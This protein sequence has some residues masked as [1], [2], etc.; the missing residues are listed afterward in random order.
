MAPDAPITM[1]EIDLREALATHILTFFVESRD[2]NGIPVRELIRRAGQPRD[3]VLAELAELVSQGQVALAFGSYSANPH[4]KRLPDLPIDE[5]L[6]RMK[7]ADVDT[8]A[9]AYPTSAVIEQRADLTPYKGQPFTRR[10]AVAD[11]QLTPVFF[12]LEVLEKYFRNPIYHFQ[13][14]DLG[15]NISIADKHY[16]SAEINER[17]KVHIDFGIAYDERRR[18]VVVA[19]L[20]YLADLSPE[21]QRIWDA[22]LAAG[23]CVMNSDYARATINGDFPEH[24][25]AYQAFLVEQVEINK[26]SVLID[27]PPLFRETFEEQK[28]PKEYMPM[29]LPTKKN[30]D[31]FV[32]TLDKMLSENINHD[33]FKGDVPLLDE[34]GR[35]KGTLNLLRDFLDKRYRDGDKN[36]IGVELV[37]PLKEVRDLRRKPAHKLEGDAHDPS[38][39]A[40]QDELL[41]RVIRTLTKLRL[42]LMSHPKAKGQYQPPEWLDGDKIVFY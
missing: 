10:L 17:D 39:P 42:V 21:H 18:R 24:W 38:L 12:D 36:R 31:A 28:R 30:F 16:Q 25:S 35:A 23:P 8:D 13:F 29:L 41:G 37:A 20:R 15:G 1:S 34:K 40:A 2:F 33:F 3:R 5:Q 27:K 9:C 4:I 6:Q 19:Y 22:H 7:R 26:L 14:N 11:A 32:H